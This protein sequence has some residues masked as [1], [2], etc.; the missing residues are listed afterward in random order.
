MFCELDAAP[1]AYHK[2]FMTLTSVIAVPYDD[3]TLPM[4]QAE[5]SVLQL[6]CGIEEAPE[7]PATFM[8]VLKVHIELMELTW[9]VTVV[10]VVPFAER[11]TW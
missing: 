3:G 6:I 2:L 11:K 9:G 7:L 4:F 10:Q 5:P 8:S 1:L